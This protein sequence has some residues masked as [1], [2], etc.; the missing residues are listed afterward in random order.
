ME[1]RAW[2]AQTLEQQFVEHRGK[3]C[4]GHL[5][6]PYVLCFGEYPLYRNSDD[7]SFYSSTASFLRTRLYS[8]KIMA[9]NHKLAGSINDAAWREFR[10]QMEYKCARH[11]RILLFVDSYYPSTQTCSFCGVKST[12]TKGLENL[13]VREWICP[14]CG[15]HLDRDINAAVNIINHALETNAA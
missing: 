13:K 8:I 11:G 15:T 4:P 12:I 9:K 3:I 10:R 5:K 7:P 6:S 1:H 14:H 2:L